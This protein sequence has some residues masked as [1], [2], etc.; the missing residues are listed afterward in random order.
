MKHSFKVLMAQ[1]F[2]AALI[3]TPWTTALAAEGSATKDYLSFYASGSDAKIGLFKDGEFP[4][5]SEL[6][7]ES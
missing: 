3:V 6:K 1:L 7:P 4:S 5:N 2:T